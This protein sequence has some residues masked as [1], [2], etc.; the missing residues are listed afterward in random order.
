M[1][2]HKFRHLLNW[3]KVIDLIVGAIK[4]CN[5][6]AMLLSVIITALVGYVVGRSRDPKEIVDL[7]EA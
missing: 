3:H 7:R 5:E 6:R 2:D 4:E 1:T